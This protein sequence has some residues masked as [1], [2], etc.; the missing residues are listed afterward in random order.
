MSFSLLLHFLPVLNLE[1]SVCSILKF[2]SCSSGGHNEYK[3]IFFIFVI[4]TEID[5]FR[6]SIDL[7]CCENPGMKKVNFHWFTFPARIEVIF[8]KDL[9]ASK[10]LT[11][12]LILKLYFIK[13][14]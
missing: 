1:T 2:L 14:S 11:V 3:I 4:A 9:S 5:I 13:I 10:K 6:W 8:Q 7:T 12:K